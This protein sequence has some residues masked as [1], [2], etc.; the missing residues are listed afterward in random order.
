MSESAASATR[1]TLNFR[2]AVL[3]W[4]LPGLGHASLGD[5][6]RGLLVGGGVLGLFLGGLLIGGLDVVDRREDHLWFLAQAGAGPV[7]WVA[8]YANANLVAS[9][10]FGELLEAPH[11][12]PM[13]PRGTVVEVSSLKSLAHPNEMGTL[14]AAMAGLMNVVAVLDAMSRRPAEAAS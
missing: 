10:R 3:G 6:R 14:F 8:D 1:T 4:I 9:G 2:A 5:R 7:A 11:P 12:D 13:A